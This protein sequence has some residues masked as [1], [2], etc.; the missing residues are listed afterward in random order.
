MSTCYMCNQEATSVEHAPPKCLF[1]EKK[2]VSAGNEYRRNLVTVPSCDEH[3]SATSRDDEHLLY[4]L[5]ASITSND[6]GLNQFLTKVKRAAE[7]N[8]SFAS[9]ILVSSE[10]VKLFHEDTQEW[11]DAF[12]MQVQG[13]R[14]DA[15][16]KKCAYALYF[17]ETKTKFQGTVTVVTGFTL[18]NVPSLNSAIASAIPTAED[19]FSQHAAK[20]DNP[21]VFFYKFEEGENT[22]IMLMYFY[23]KSKVLVRFD[24]R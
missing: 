15:V 18:Y 11:K 5:S 23:E 4:M 3:N 13:N 24:K 20:G 21:D 7:R 6:V 9:T 14:L 10:P 2:D 16:F 8:P 22:G 19:Y 17:H 12:G 1:P